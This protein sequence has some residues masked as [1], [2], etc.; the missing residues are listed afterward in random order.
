[1]KLKKLLST[2]YGIVF[3]GLGILI[4]VGIVVYSFRTRKTDGFQ[5]QSQVPKIIWSY[6][7]NPETMPKT[8]TLCMESWKKYNPSY[9]IRMLNKKN[10]TDYVTIPVEIANHPRFNDMPQRFADLLRCYLIAEHGGVW[11]DSSI[12]M[13]QSLDE[14][15]WTEPGKDLYVFS[16]EFGHHPGRAPVLENWFFAAPPR[17]PFVQKWLTEFLELMK[18]ES[19]KA[20]VDDLVRRGLDNKD[21]CCTDYLAMHHAAGKVLQL[22]KYPVNRLKIWPT[23]KG[24]FRYIVENGWN[25]DAAFEA[26]CKDPSIRKPFMKMRGVER[27]T[28]ETGL[29]DKFSNER[30]KWI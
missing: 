26:A 11:C 22:D 18:F 29:A 28:L 25:A 24:P 2:P 13:F 4:C 15:M 9:T 8:V 16:I 12:L 7:D 6:W 1:M 27:G 20:Y 10:Y 3:L 19:A 14:W 21:W 30:C 23:E 17:S 5:N